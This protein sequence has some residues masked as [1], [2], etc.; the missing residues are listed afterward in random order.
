MTKINDINVLITG[1]G[2]YPDGDGGHID[3]NTSHLITTLLPKTLDPNTPLNPSPTRINIITLPDPVK[4]EYKYVREFCKD[5]HTKHAEDVDLFIHLGEARGWDWLTIERVAYKQG[6]SST[7]WGPYYGPQEYYLWKDDKDL[8]VKDIGPCPWDGVPMGLQSFLN[9]DRVAD[10]ANT[11]LK[12]L[13]QFGKPGASVAT[14]GN[15]DDNVPM[16]K[17]DATEA[18]LP[19]NIKPH[20]EGGPMMCGFINYESLANRYVRKLKPNVLFCH[21]PGEADAKNL[22]RTGDGILAIVVAAAAEVLRLDL[23]N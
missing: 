16:P 10:G 12:T 7:W 3:V 23:M 14:V 22:K 18:S 5:L 8:T 21:I 13:Y 20:D 17:A 4:T 2:P 1:M 15:E 11:I 9:P 6:M 19:I